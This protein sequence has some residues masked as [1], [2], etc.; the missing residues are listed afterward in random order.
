MLFRSSSSPVHTYYTK[1]YLSIA[2]KIRSVSSAIIDIKDIQ[3]I[4][5]FLAERDIN[6]LSRV[7]LL[8]K[9]GINIA[10]LALL[11]GNSRIEVPLTGAEVYN[12]GLVKKILVAGGIGKGT[13]YLYENVE[14]AGFNIGSLEGKS[15]AEIFKSILL[16]NGVDE[17]DILPLD[18]TSQIGRAHV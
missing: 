14:N 10:D 4:I 12:K 15:E 1:I 6:E 9:Y 3:K 8:K 17:K 11:F 18:T 2:R 16:L 5:N 7:S 13:P